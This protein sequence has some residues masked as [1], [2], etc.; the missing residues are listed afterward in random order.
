M[1]RD[2]CDAGS[3]RRGTCFIDGDAPA[4]GG[5]AQ[6]LVF[7]GNA[8]G[9]AGGAVYVE[10]EAVGPACMGALNRTVALPLAGGAAAPRLLFEGNRRHL[11]TV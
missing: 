7:A 9:V 5:G 1:Y 6:Q 8:A 4:A 3:A 2:T 10:C 11:T